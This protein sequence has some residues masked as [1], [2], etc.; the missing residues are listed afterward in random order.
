MRDSKGSSS[1]IRTEAT[2]PHRSWYGEP[3]E[4]AFLE[5]IPALALARRAGV[6][7]AMITR[8]GRLIDGWVR[9]GDPP[10]VHLRDTPERDPARLALW[11]NLLARRHGALA[12]DLSGPSTGVLAAIET[13]L[14]YEPI[15][16]SGRALLLEARGGMLRLSRLLQARP[17]F[18]STG[19]AGAAPLGHLERWCQSSIESFDPGHGHLT[20]VC[21]AEDE[22]VRL[23]ASEAEGILRLLLS[24]AWRS[25]MGQR[26]RV[27]VTGRASGGWV[28]LEVDD[29]GKGLADDEALERA[30]EWGFSSR[31]D[32]A[33]LSLFWVRWVLRDRG[34][35]LIQRK[36]QGA[37]VSVFLRP[38]SA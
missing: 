25:R 6:V 29:E 28:E 5:A 21:R 13:V 22:T 7:S 12:H 1:A 36:N 16:E 38:N 11:M 9:T 14:E 10:T 32:G 17:L 24:N 30:G 34:A 37:T 27:A 8:D 3:V 18:E 2:G 35:V 31:H 23:D 20:L 26:V 4:R 15:T 19:D 33:G